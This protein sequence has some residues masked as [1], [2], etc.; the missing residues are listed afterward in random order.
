MAIFIMS[1]NVSG[2][3][4]GQLFQ[5]EDAPAYRTG[6][7]VIA[8]LVSGALAM[9]VLANLQYWLLNKYQRREGE[10]RYQY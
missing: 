4:G 7:T 5:A 2:I 10:A 3:I 1:A 8:G 6:W 9:S